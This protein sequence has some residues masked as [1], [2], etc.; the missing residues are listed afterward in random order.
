MNIWGWWERYAG[1]ETK[2]KML[3]SLKGL[4][5]SWWLIESFFVH[6]FLL[7]S[8]DSERWLKIHRFPYSFLCK[9]SSSLCPLYS[10]PGKENKSSSRARHLNT[11]SILIRY[12]LYCEFPNQ[13]ISVVRF[14]RVC[15]SLKEDD[16]DSPMI[17]LNAAS[18]SPCRRDAWFITRKMMT[19]NK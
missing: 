14:R 13:L 2:L 18:A 12:W 4:L 6:F 5:L 7:T 3:S 10:A 1:C 15:L 16:H 8:H 19:S 9:S 11:R 17:V